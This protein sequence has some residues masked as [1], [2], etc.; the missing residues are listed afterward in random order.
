MASGNPLTERK[1]VLRFDLHKSRGE[2]RAM[3]PAN[4]SGR[5]N[6]LSNAHQSASTISFKIAS[7]ASAGSGACVMGRPTTR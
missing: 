6:S 5:E 1:P 7:A 3:P 4:L 2:C